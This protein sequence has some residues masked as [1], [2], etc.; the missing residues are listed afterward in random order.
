LRFI[1]RGVIE[2]VN[3]KNADE[4]L[5]ERAIVFDCTNEEGAVAKIIKQYAYEDMI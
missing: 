4:K 2:K 1:R 3:D 5:K